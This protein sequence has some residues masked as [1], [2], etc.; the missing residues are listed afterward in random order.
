V[1]AV[2]VA[3]RFNKKGK[4]ITWDKHTNKQANTWHKTKTKLGRVHFLAEK[5]RA[6]HTGTQGLGG[7]IFWPKKA[8]A[9]VARRNPELGRVHC[10][11]EKAFAGAARKNP[12]LGR[13]HS[14]AE[15]SF[16]GRCTQVKSASPSTPSLHPCVVL[17]RDA[18]SERQCDWDRETGKLKDTIVNF[19]NPRNLTWKCIKGDKNTQN[20]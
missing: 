11:A 14:L 19:P 9:G 10:L 7:C 12:E 17:L 3:A 13:V 1:G 8:F 18:E 2:A 20:N 15:K 4:F 16:R 6:L 5:L